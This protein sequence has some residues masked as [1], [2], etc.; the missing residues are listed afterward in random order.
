MSFTN[1]T[2]QRFFDEHGDYVRNRSQTLFQDGETLENT[3][4]GFGGLRPPPTDAHELAK[5]LCTY[6]EIKAKTAATEFHNYQGTLDG[7][8]G[9]LIFE[10]TPAKQLAKLK[11]L[12]RSRPAHASQVQC[13]EKRSGRNYSGLA[14]CQAA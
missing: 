14:H 10:P 12:R 13:G 6:W 8:I 7:S 11:E 3:L 9:G 1:P 5:L 2:V 4:D